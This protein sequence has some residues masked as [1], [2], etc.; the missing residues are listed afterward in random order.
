MIVLGVAGAVIWQSDGEGGLA[1]RATEASIPEMRI[2]EQ[3]GRWEQTGRVL[4]ADRNRTVQFTAKDDIY[5]ALGGRAL[6]IESVYDTNG[7]TDEELA[8]KTHHNA[9]GEYTQTLFTDKGHVVGFRGEWDSLERSMTWQPY[10]PTNN[11]PQMTV[12]LREMLLAPGQKR[13][14]SQYRHFA[15]TV[16]DVRTESHRTGD[17]FGSTTSK[18]GSPASEELARLGQAGDLLEQQKFKQ[19]D[20]MLK[21]LIHGQARWAQ[22]GRCLV[23]EGEVKESDIDKPGTPLLWVKTYD[24]AMG[25][26]CYAYF[27]ENGGVDHY[28][29]SW[30]PA[31]KTLSWRSIKTA[32]GEDMTH[33]LEETIEQPGLRRW[34]YQAR[35]FG[36]IVAEG[37]GISRLQQVE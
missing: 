32:G 20:N 11:A 9:T 27:W 10:F 12:V 4:Y 23:F 31:K 14:R 15:M 6:M 26:Y 34:K 21:T 30:N 2:M 22:G 24:Q 8:I 1:P 7:S 13:M 28:V 25:V 33:T 3:A 16:K 36:K 17:G 35:E 19:G 29:G 18:L 37:E 5:W